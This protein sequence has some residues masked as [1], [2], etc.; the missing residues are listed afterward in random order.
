MHHSVYK[1]KTTIGCMPGVSMATFNVDIQH[2]LVDL[3]SIG[4]QHEVVFAVAADVHG[5]HAAETDGDEGGDFVFHVDD[6]GTTWQQ[7]FDTCRCELNTL[8]SV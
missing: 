4:V 7:G 2:L 3:V 8:L 6:E 5:L 1:Q